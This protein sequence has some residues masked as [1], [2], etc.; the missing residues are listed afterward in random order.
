MAAV[1]VPPPRDDLATTRPEAET[2][3]LY[4]LER[5]TRQAEPPPLPVA[6]L[7][8]AFAASPAG[9]DIALRSGQELSPGPTSI[10][11]LESYCAA[12]YGPTGQAP[13]S[14]DWQPSDAEE[15]VILHWGAFLGEA[16]IATYGGVWECDP[17]APSDPRLFRVIVQD[18]VAA[19]PMT[20]VYLRLKNGPR[21]DM[22]Q[23]IG[24]LG[25]LLA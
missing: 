23:F 24:A 3:P 8:R 19:W 21:H 12:I 6:S 11:A 14:P 18:K 1:A 22:M 2:A 16:I 17:N 7:A 15:T 10:E 13:T 9:Q 25:R 5:P 4:R 20:L